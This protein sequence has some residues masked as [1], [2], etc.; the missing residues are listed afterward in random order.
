MQTLSW[1]PNTLVHWISVAGLPIGNT[2][3]PPRGPGELIG[4]Q[5]L[6]RVNMLNEKDKSERRQQMAASAPQSVDQPP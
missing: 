6:S 1:P 4:L 3:E 2:R 5:F